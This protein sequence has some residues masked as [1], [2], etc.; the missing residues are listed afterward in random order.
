MRQFPILINM[1]KFI[2]SI[3]AICVL[4]VFLLSAVPAAAQKQEISESDYTNR[5]VE[6]ADRFREEGK[7]YV[8]VAVIVVLLAGMLTYMIVLDRKVSKLEKL[9][10]DS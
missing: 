10:Q 9:H 6:M 8:V 2:S 7:I 1:K 3:F 5:Q 4:S